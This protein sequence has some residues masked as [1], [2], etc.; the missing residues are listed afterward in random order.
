ME[1]KIIEEVVGGI[2]RR[3][4]SKTSKDILTDLLEHW[5]HEIQQPEFE[6]K[7]TT[8]SWKINDLIKRLK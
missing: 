8:L 4:N 1:I 7:Y 3:V 2:E 6:G 5:N